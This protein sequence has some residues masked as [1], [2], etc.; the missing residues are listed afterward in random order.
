MQQQLR[1]AHDHQTS[2]HE[3]YGKEAP[4]HI[5][6]VV[7]SATSREAELISSIH[8]GIVDLVLLQQLEQVRNELVGA[9]QV[10]ENWKGSSTYWEDQAELMETRVEEL[11]R[12]LAAS[13]ERSGADTPTFSE[14]CAS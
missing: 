4:K 1:Q 6:S 2:L 9:R 13:G 11:T 7:A 3:H 14:R 8:A 10:A 5:D 12:K